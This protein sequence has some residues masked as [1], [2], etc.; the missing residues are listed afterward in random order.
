MR[1]ISD[2]RKRGK[3]RPRV[4]SVAVTVRIPPADLE[5]IDRWIDAQA[6]APS[7]PAAIRRLVELALRTS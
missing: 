7:R 3:G 5:A 1:S 4:D 2:V 6:D